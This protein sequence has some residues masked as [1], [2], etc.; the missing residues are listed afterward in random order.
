[1]PR[2]QTVSLCVR[3]D[4]LR[5]RWRSV[6]LSE[7]ADRAVHEETEDHQQVPAQEVSIG[8]LMITGA[9]RL[10]DLTFWKLQFS[11]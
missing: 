7:P 5:F 4:R 2:L 8:G 9:S 6:C 1:M 10:P 3:Q 11:L